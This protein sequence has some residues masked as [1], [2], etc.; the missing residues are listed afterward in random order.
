MVNIADAASLHL[1]SAM[2]LEAWINPSVIDN[3]WRDVVYKGQNIYFLEVN[4]DQG[5]LP[6]AGGTFGVGGNNATYGPAPL[7]KS[8][9]VHLAVTYNGAQIVLYINGA[10]VSSK[11]QTGS[12]LAST[13]PLQIGGDNDYGQYFKGVI[14]E[15]RVYNR[16]LAAS[17]IQTDMITPV[18]V[19][20]AVTS[21]QTPAVV[22]TQAAVSVAPAVNAAQTAATFTGAVS[23]LGC[24]PRTAK[25]G[26]QVR[27]ELTVQR[28][29]T[30]MGIQLA[31]SSDQVKVPGAVFARADQERLI[32]QASVN[33]TAKDQTV[34]ISAAF[35]GQT[36]GD[37][38]VVVAPTGPVITTPGKQFARFGT[39]LSFYVAGADANNGAVQLTAAHLPPGA[40]FDWLKGQFEWTP[41]VAQAGQYEVTFTATDAAQRSSTANVHIDVAPGVPE[42]TGDL[43]CSPGAIGTLNGKWLAE[44]GP[45]RS[46][47]SGAA[48]ELGGTKVRVNGQYVPV[49][50]V[51]PTRVSFVCPTVDAGTALAVAVEVGESASIPLNTT[52]LAA[53]PE[54]FR[55]D[56]FGTQGVVTFAGSNTVAAMRSFAVNG[57]P[58][59]P[60]DQLVIWATGLGAPGEASL[61]VKV[62]G[63]DA[64]VQSVTAVP[65]YAGLCAVQVRVPA[66]AL[67]DTIPVILEVATPVARFASNIVTIAVEAEVQ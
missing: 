18:S 22:K 30:A 44:A 25:A 36:V 29:G 46:N 28:G 10:P 15:V 26:Q 21:S 61:V 67:G 47:T 6:A 3:T 60:G 62:G 17:E 31:S 53:S 37:T 32:F 2:T 16:A 24:S 20:G 34:T 45:A 19:A 58:A 4:S 27:C 11:A 41:T 33:A 14:D 1:G 50:F 59:Q 63:V 66:A 9:W 57:H 55:L 12:I 7:K 43:R 40:Y 8:Q 51:S 35:A 52:V 38:L 42:L 56:G 23:F 64:E 54:V 39:S 49:L 5:S 65:G 48:L 13:K